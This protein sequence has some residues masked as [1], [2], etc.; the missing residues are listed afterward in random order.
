MTNSINKIHGTVIHDARITEDMVTRLE[1]SSIIEMELWT[2]EDETKD[3]WELSDIQKKALQVPGKS[4]TL[5]LHATP[6]SYEEEIVNAGGVIPEETERTIKGIIEIKDSN[7][8]IVDGNDWYWL[9]NTDNVL[10]LTLIE[11]KETPDV[12]L[13]EIYA[14]LLSWNNAVFPTTP[15]TTTYFYTSGTSTDTI[16]NTLG[17]CFDIKTL[18]KG[19]YYTSL[20][21]LTSALNADGFGMNDV[22]LSK[23]VCSSGQLRWA[24]D[25]NNIIACLNGIVAGSFVDL[26]YNYITWAVSSVL[27]EDGT[28]VK[29]YIVT[30]LAAE[31][32]KS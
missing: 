16:P 4:M 14:T 8:G 32:I 19:K 28:G 29:G 18:Y 25:E 5:I 17:G 10:T 1:A 15:G 30:C 11:V 13:L 31:E 12:Q 9:N 22:D 2:S 27:S 24:N 26:D 23:M 7:F 20:T 6:K 3:G 21:A